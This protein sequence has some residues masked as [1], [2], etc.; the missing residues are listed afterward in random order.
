MSQQ[1]GT[2]I[3]SPKPDFQIQPPPPP[4]PPCRGGGHGVGWGDSDVSGY[5]PE[6]VLKTLHELNFT[7]F[8]G[9]LLQLGGTLK[10]FF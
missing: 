9:S 10:H 4:P 6:I 5:F 7:C 3:T 1:E 8:F 2:L